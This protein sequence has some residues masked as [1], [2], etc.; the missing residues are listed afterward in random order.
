MMLRNLEECS[1]Q[2]SLGTIQST[3]DPTTRPTTFRPRNSKKDNIIKKM[4]VSAVWLGSRPW[5]PEEQRE[6][7]PNQKAGTR[8]TM[9]S[10]TAHR[11]GV[12]TGI[13]G[14]ATQ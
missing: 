12:K 13:S 8:I 14:R 11:S 5:K 4:R 1:T 2:S 3:L 9:E 7:D 10:S 6:T